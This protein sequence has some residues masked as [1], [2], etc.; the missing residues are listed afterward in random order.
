MRVYLIHH[1]LQKSAAEFPNRV[2]LRFEDHELTYAE[3]DAQANQTA[4]ALQMAGVR[5]G[6]RVG[7]YVRKSLASVISIFAILKAGGV[8]VPLDPDAP[9]KRLAFIISNAHIR[10]LL[11]ADNM[12]ARLAGILEEPT[13]LENVIVVGENGVEAEFD[14]ERLS[15]MPWQ[16]VLAQPVTSLPE[17]GTIDNDL[18]YILYTSGSTG[19]PKGVMISHRAS[20][21]FIDWCYSTFQ[22]T[23][24]D[25]ITGHAP[26]HFDL[27]TFDI[28]VTIKAGATLVLV[29]EKLAVFPVHL[30]RLLQDET[31]TVTYLVPSVLSLM[32]N[33]GQLARHDLSRLRLVLFAGE[34][35]PIK[36]LRQLV[37]AHPTADY[38]NLYGPTETN[39][40]TY[41]RVRPEDV[42]AER[43][44]PVP[45]GV[46]CSNIEVFALDE[47]GQPVTDPD[48]EGELWV[49]GAC[50]AEGYWGDAEKTGRSFVR[51]R[52]QPNFVDLAYRTGDIVRLAPDCRNWMYI[53]RRDHMVKSRGYRI[54]LGEI[55][56]VLYGHTAVREA[57][58]VAVPDDLLGNRIKAYVVAADCNDQAA[59][60]IVEHCK[61]RLPGYM[62]PESIVFVDSLP[63]TSTGK[64]DRT[65]LL[66]SSTA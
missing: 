22:V 58:V 43:T 4:R 45:I 28:F 62:V 65:R 66:Q 55:E 19:E 61:Q 3:L 8:Y 41:Y 56:T 33:Y 57:V 18:A 9:A 54:E 14:A 63:K 42:A 47:H 26:L 29:P 64:I 17:Q 25:R 38:Y 30:V 37:Q 12:A 7:I 27:S 11:T 16:E 36:Y 40:C 5:R 23:E 15:V 6:D 39:V 1:L 32:I 24:N 10:A 46:A 2:A 50:L 52:L 53:G 59:T 34:V 35:F 60:Q 21:T 20:L 48:Q 13:P 31:I 44:Q 51:N 49:R